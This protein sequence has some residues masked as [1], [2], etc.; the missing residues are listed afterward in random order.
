M[1]HSD[2]K[3]RQ[4]ARSLLP[5]KS[6]ANARWARARV[7]RAARREVHEELTAWL[8]YRNVEVDAPPCAPWEDAKIR[9][10]MDHRRAGDKVNPFIRWA[11]ARTRDL[12]REVRRSFV[13][14]LLPQ[15]VIGEHALGHLEQTPAFETPMMAK[16]RERH[17]QLQALRDRG[18]RQDRGEQAQLLRALLLKPDGQRTFNRFLRERYTWAS[19][20]CN[21]AAWPRREGLPPHRPLLG[22]HDVLPFLDTVKPDRWGGSVRVWGM[23]DPPAHWMRLFLQRFKEHRGHIPSVRAAL[24]AEGLLKPLPP[25]GVRAPGR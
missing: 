18:T 22:V 2:E 19:S 5:S 8:K 6:P 20:Q 24:E 3:V 10:V 7:H 12:P 14:G 17:Q 23:L 9:Q 25:E 15:G 11:T 1:I 21:R 13:R 4:M 16:E